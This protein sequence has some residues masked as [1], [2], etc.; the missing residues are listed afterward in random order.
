MQGRGHHSAMNSRT[1]N[2]LCCHEALAAGRG[3]VDATLAPMAS[4]ISRFGA[5][6]R[7]CDHNNRMSML[8]GA[9]FNLE[10]VLSD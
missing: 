4:M 9:H 7:S 2:S 1:K 8:A 10:A 3:I 6:D 5:I